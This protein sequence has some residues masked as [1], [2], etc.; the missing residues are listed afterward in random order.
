MQNKKLSKLVKISLLSV[1]AFL[2]MYFIEIPIPIFPGFLKL[3]ISD[4][5]AL[6]GGF[7]L[8]P[9]A[10]IAIEL[11]K[12]LLHGILKSNTMWI[13][14]IAN[15]SIGA[16][17]VG[18]SACIYNIRKTRMTALIGM[19]A[20]VIAM[21]V[22]A[23]TLNFYILIPAYSKAFN[24]PIEAFVSMASKFNSNIIDLKTLII[25]SIIP[26]NLFKGAIVS[27]VTMLLYKSVSPI[28]HK[29]QMVTAK[30]KNTIKAFSKK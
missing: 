29:E 6:I 8:G 28:L 13:G 1:M 12:N 7:A 11:I 21:S 2:L 16:V 30:G 15:F 22:V 17:L 27:T 24:A 4:L 3:D 18:V 23:A 14:E 19:I 25:W 5:P 10:G 20:G 9:V 26:F